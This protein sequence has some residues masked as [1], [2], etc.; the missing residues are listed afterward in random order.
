MKKFLRLA[1]LYAM[2]AIAGGV[3]F[4]EFTKYHGYTG[5]T[6]LSFVHVHLFVL[7]TLVFLILALYADRGCAAD[8]KGLRAFLVLYNLGLPLMT[9]MFLLRG[10]LQVLGTPLS[11]GA[12]AAVSGVAGISHTLLTLALILLFRSL[13]R[14]AGA[15]GARGK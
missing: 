7:G 2:A 8:R 3:F 13:R 5:P 12:S 15:E 1:F 11:P 10:T 14:L 4:R 6:A 9:G